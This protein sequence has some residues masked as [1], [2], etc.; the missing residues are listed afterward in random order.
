M[1]NRIFPLLPIAFSIFIVSC[2][3][4]PA[5]DTGAKDKV[6]ISDSMMKMITI[7]TA[8]YRNVSNEL[9]LSGEVS[10]DDNKVVKVFPFSSGQVQSVNVSVGDYV[11]AGQVIATIKS[12]DIAGNYADLSSASADI[13][14]AKR[15]MDNAEH[16]FKNG[17]SSEKEYMEAKENYDKAV[18]NSAKIQEQ[19]NINGGGRTSAN[20]TYVVTAPKNGYVVER[21]INPGQFIRNDNGQN[22]FTIGD[23]KDVW[24]WANVYESDIA[25]VKEGYT[26]DVTTLSYPDSVF[27]GKVDK[28]SQVLDPVTKVMKI[29][30]VLPN[31]GGALKPEMFAN[32]TIT[33][34]EGENAMSIPASSIVTENGKSYVVLYHDKC[35]LEVKEIKVMKVLGKIAFINSGINEGDK[36]IS[37]NQLLLYRQLIEP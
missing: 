19:I 30:V 32:V 14:I 33:N 20:G 22:L 29:K 13:A 31:E 9:K 8:Q 7:D 24:I 2:T 27:V 35:D 28:V 21:T 34:K 18:A 6:C 1:T 16:L 11:K 3:S 17:I 26:A 36:V 12:A 23:T 37:T 5:S 4:T 25:K 15:Q 10:F